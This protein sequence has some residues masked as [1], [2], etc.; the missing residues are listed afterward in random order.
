ARRIFPRERPGEYEKPERR[1]EQNP[2][3]LY[4]LRMMVLAY[5]RRSLL[6]RALRSATGGTIVICDRFPSSTP[7]A[8]DSVHFAGE[9]QHITHSR[10]KRNLMRIEE[11]PLRAVYEATSGG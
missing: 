9:T 11:R 3:L 5:D 8:M 10:L 4:I 1:S 6:R 2:S 7:G